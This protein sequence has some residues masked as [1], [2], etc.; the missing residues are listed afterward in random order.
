MS[1]LAGSASDKPTG[2]DRPAEK[3]RPTQAQHDA[4]WE[5]LDQLAALRSNE[6]WNDQKQRWVETMP[7]ADRAT[8]DVRKFR[9]YSMD[10]G[11]ER[12][13]GKHKGWE[14]LGYDVA[15]DA[16]RADL[17]ERVSRMVRERLPTAEVTRERTDELG[18]R[19][20]E[21]SFELEGATASDRAG[22]LRTVWLLDE[23]G[24]SPRMITNWVEVH[25]DE[26]GSR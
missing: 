22:T 9:D 13:Q 21:V 24:E 12:N 19:R 26:K 11:N 14:Q 10:P 23:G 7:G 1:D 20:F 4:Q 25:R 18:G 5:S 6:R 15:D 17:S 8:L 16:T 3:D 2:S